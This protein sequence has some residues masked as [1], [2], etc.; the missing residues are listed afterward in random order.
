MLPR[1]MSVKSYLRFIIESE[2]ER[3]IALL[4]D[5]DGDAES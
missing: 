5:L 4:D 1:L 3:L 2:I